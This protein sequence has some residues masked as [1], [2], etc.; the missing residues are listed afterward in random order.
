[1]TASIDDKADKLHRAFQKWHQAFDC[2]SL[3]N[4]IYHYTDFGGLGG[5]LA[6]QKLWCTDYRYLNDPTELEFGKS[7]IFRAVLEHSALTPKVIFELF[8]KLEYVYHVYTVSF[9]A[10]INKLS[11]WR[12]Y[13]NNG[14]GFAIGF[15]KDF[16]EPL[17]NQSEPD[18]LDACVCKVNYGEQKNIKIVEGFIKEF[19]EICNT[20]SERDKFISTLLCHFIRILPAIKDESFQDEYEIRL[21]R[22]EGTLLDAYYPDKD[23]DFIQRKKIDMPFVDAISGNKPVL[24]EEFKKKQIAEIVV[25]PC[26]SF[27]E[28][29]A[30]IRTLLR[31]WGYDPEKIVIRPC[32]L[33]F[34]AS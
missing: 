31:N 7:V 22:A 2:G 5:I 26:C 13:A 4:I 24:T 1:M 3:P 30:N 11:L 12:Y 15:K 32:P 16:F 25:G 18:A 23:R 17:K 33:S 29:R 21:Y 28:A 20:P 34:R 19:L 14:T 9:S 27:M 8:K 6:S 10:E